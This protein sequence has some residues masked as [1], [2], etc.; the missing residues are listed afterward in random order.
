MSWVNWPGIATEITPAQVHISLQVLSS[1][2]W[3]V[4]S[5]LTAPGTQGAGVTGTQG[6]GV[7]TP[8]AAAVAAMTCGFD[9]E[10]HIPKG[11]MLTIGTWSMIVPAGM[12]LVITGRGVALNTDGTA[13]KLHCSWAPVQTCLGIVAFLAGP[14]P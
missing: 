1:A 12:L 10:L 13:P 14:E 6:I 3:L 9:G 2:G 7:N 8:I 5:T 4:I 11:M